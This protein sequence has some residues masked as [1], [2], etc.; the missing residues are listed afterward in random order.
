MNEKIQ[1]MIGSRVLIRSDK[2]GVH[3]GTLE[4]VDGEVIVLSDSRRCWRWWARKGRSLSAVAVHGL[5]DRRE[6]AISARVPLIAVNGWIEI[7]PMTDSAHQSVMDAP[8]Q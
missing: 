7:L 8:E 6:V 5:A 1:G 3:A 2:S 4:S